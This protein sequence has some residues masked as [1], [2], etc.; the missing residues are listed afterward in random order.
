MINNYVC[1]PK[2]NG[3]EHRTKNKKMRKT[4]SRPLGNINPAN[5]KNN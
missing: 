3:L 4:P 1:R 2:K 5:L